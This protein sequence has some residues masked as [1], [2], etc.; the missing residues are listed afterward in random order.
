MSDWRPHLVIHEVAELAAPMISTS[1]GIPYVDVGYGSLI[2]RALLLAAGKAVGPHWH[3]RGLEPGPLAGMFR[4]LYIDPC[5]PTLQN[6]EI[7][8]LESVRSSAVVR[9]CGRPRRSRNS[10]RRTRPRCPNARPSPRCRSVDEC[11]TSHSGWRRS[12]PAP[13]RSQRQR[14]SPRSDTAARRALLPPRVHNN[15]E[16]DTSHAIGRGSDDANRST[17]QVPPTCGERPDDG[18]ET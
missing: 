12:A 6:L 3:A 16:R 4:H 7:A 8:D 18:L 9:R 13:Q 11:R 5:P 1:M 15:S 17:H 10:A 14:H 2:P